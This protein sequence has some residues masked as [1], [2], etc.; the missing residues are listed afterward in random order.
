M[1]ASSHT[2][3]RMV[4]IEADLILKSIRQFPCAIFELTPPLTH[5]G[6]LESWQLF[7]NLTSGS[8]SVASLPIARHCCKSPYCLTVVPVLSGSIFT[9]FA[10]GHC[11][12]A[13]SN[14]VYSAGKL[15]TLTT[16]ANEKRWEKVKPDLSQIIKS[17]A[18][19]DVVKT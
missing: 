12:N 9:T 18:V 4:I 8:A 15:Y 17:F 2:G 16:G 6:S 13:C 1:A 3:H 7:N 19:D 11:L 14:L 5:Q 10:D